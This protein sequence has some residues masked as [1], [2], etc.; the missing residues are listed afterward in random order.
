[1]LGLKGM[2]S[3]ICVLYIWRG[4]LPSAYLQSGYLLL[5]LQMYARTQCIL[6]ES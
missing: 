5:D 2:E 6:F 3:R 1:M 4:W